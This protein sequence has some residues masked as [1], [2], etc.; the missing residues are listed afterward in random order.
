MTDEF[1]AGVSGD[2]D[3]ADRHV[4][5]DAGD[6]ETM[7]EV[8]GADSIDELVEQTIPEEILDRSPLE[9]ETARDEQEQ[10]EVARKLAEQNEEYRSFIGMGYREAVVPPVIQRNILENPK[11]YTHYTPYQSEISQG[12]LE[13][14]LN[15]Q[16]MCAD[17]T[18]LDVANASLLDEATAAA[19]A[20]SMLRRVS[21]R[22]AGNRFL[23]SD[24]CHPQTIAVVQ[25]RAEPVGIE[26]DVRPPDAFEFGD[27]TFGALVQYPTT[28][29]EVVDHSDLCSRAHDADTLVAAAADLLALTLFR[30]PGEFGADVAVGSTQR[31][32]IPSGYGGPHAAYF[33]TRDRYKRKMPGRLIGVSKDEHGE[34]AY[35]MALQ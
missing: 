29:G 18:G 23:V 26:V 9:L 1:T 22:S 14:L 4:G 7:L 28:D 13:A 31:F 27:D 25:T 3:F 8:V 20:M 2:S 5:P 19:E 15:F 34:A 21:R 12:R 24:R 33:A 35:R 30:P 11:W 32:G 10:L 17:L 6:V 16:T